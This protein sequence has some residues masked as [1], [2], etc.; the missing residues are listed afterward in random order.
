MYTLYYTHNIHG[1]E[2][3][4][5]HGSTRDQLLWSAK[6]ADEANQPELAIDHHLQSLTAPGCAHE[7]RMG[8]Q[9]G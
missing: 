4:V 5:V 8:V 3:E 1:I 2:H 7:H 9:H 6:R